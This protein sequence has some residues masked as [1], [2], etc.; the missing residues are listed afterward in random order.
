ML[1]HFLV[2]PAP[3]QNCRTVN[4][5]TFPFLTLLLFPSRAWTALYLSP[6]RAACDM[7]REQRIG[8][9]HLLAKTRDFLDSFCQYEVVHISY[10]K[11]CEHMDPVSAWIEATTQHWWWRTTSYL[12]EELLTLTKNVPAGLQVAHWQMAKCWK[13]RTPFISCLMFLL[14][15]KKLFVLRH[16]SD[17]SCA[18]LVN[19]TEILVIGGYSSRWR[20][21]NIG[22]IASDQPWSS[23]YPDMEPAEGTHGKVHR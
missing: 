13:V 8:L 20:K 7:W 18:L 14:K 9:L 6:G 16:A 5:Q 1:K 2:E 15:G 10:C 4:N 17:R 21:E 23:L 3:Y 19:K 12:L 22:D 11:L